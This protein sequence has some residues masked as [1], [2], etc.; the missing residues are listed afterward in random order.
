M[1][2]P[3]QEL[4]TTSYAILGFL[5]IKPW[6]TYE[7]A[8]QMERTLNRMWP[9]ARSK[10]YEEPKKLVARGLAKASDETVGKR[11]RTVYS[12]TPA[13]RRALASWLHSP[14]SGP[15]LEFEQLIQVFFAD[16]GTAQDARRTLAATRS[17]A[18]DGLRTFHEAATSYVDGGGPFP[19]RAATNELGA[20]FMVDFYDTVLKWSE[21]ASAVVATWPDDPSAARTDRDLFRDIVRR[22]A[23]ILQRSA[24][25]DDEFRG[26]RPS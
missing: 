25:E 5:A 2:R 8:T 11:P 16:H 24:R 4:T 20:R 13:G 23:A 10:L 22:T 19:E 21:W 18:L 26:L 3:K 12:I 14:G 15:S 6:S 7:L 17:F 9:R 1:S